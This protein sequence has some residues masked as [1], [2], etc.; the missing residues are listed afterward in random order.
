MLLAVADATAT[1]PI[2]ARFCRW[3]ISS[4]RTSAANMPRDLVDR[5]D[6]AVGG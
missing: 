1:P 4:W 2:V 5:D 6:L 3:P